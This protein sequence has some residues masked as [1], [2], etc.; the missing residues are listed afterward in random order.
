MGN[1]KIE[2]VPYLVI[3]AVGIAC[4]VDSVDLAWLV[5]VIGVRGVGGSCRGL[6]KS[7]VTDLSQMTLLATAATS[8]SVLPD[9][10]S[11][12]FMGGAAACVA[13][14][15]QFWGLVFPLCLFPVGFWR[16][17]IWL[18]LERSWSWQCLIRTAVA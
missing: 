18:R 11:V 3:R 16:I 10:T 15:L 7:G 8:G 13:A 6:S 9:R 14:A 1:G 5:S 4:A 17:T 2:S 12:G